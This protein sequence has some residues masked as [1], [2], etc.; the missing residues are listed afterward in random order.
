MAKVKWGM[1]AEKL[2]SQRKSG[3]IPRSIKA[4]KGDSYYRIAGRV[5]PYFSNNM[6]G[7]QQWGSFLESANMSKPLQPGTKVRIPRPPIY[8]RKKRARF[9]QAPP[10]TRP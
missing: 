5:Y 2:A 4:Q 7:G 9:N 10:K 6:Y 1:I 8:N 3:K